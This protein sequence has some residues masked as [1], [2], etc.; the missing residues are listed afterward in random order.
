MLR[1]FYIAANGLINQQ[2]TLN[3]ISNNVSNSQTPGYKA[4]TAVHN[5]FHKE[6]IMLKNGKLSEGGTIEYKY[7]ELTNTGLT[8]GG[9]EFTQRPL[10]VA[11]QGPV[12]FNVKSSDGEE[13]LSRSGQ[14]SIDGEG[15]LYLPGAG[16]VQG[17]NGEI[18][19]GNSDFSISSSG[20]VLSN[21]TQIGK[22][23][24]SYVEES[25]N[26]EKSGNNT[27][28]LLEGQTGEI[29]EGTDY[30]II[31]GAYERS[32]VDVSAE[33]TKAIAAQRAFESMSQAIKQID[34]INQKAA[35]ELAKI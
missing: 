15:Y 26:I 6:L 8:Q 13:L 7:T 18:Q 24:L 19:V 3:T 23:K 17:E 31:Q 12:F 20:E 1:G 10:D 14:F 25:G 5:T 16:R 35:L 11:I 22:L 34:T 4:D 27:Y 28:K 32:N 29:P 33:M 2:R 21:G 9:F 30:S